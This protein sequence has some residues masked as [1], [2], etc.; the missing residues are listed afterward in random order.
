MEELEVTMQ[1]YYFSVYSRTGNEPCGEQ[2]QQPLDLTRN[3]SETFRISCFFINSEPYLKLVRHI[4]S[5]R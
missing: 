4:I 2:Q 3:I 1:R 5:I